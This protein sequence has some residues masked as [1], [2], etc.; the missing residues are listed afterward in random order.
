[1]LFQL[2]TRFDAINSE[3]LQKLNFQCGIINNE[4]KVS[5]LRTTLNVTGIGIDF[6]HNLSFYFVFM[7]NVTYK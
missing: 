4:N 7:N 3:H 1:M 5:K 2:S 6:R